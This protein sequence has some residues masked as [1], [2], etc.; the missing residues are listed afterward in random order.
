M[1]FGGSGVVSWI[2]IVIVV[3]HAASSLFNSHLAD[4]LHGWLYVFGA[5][6]VGGMVLQKNAPEKQAALGLRS[7][8]D[9]AGR[10]DAWLRPDPPDTQSP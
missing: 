4:S 6:I 1:L 2:G 7:R 5:G 9:A 8:T 10:A 3:Q